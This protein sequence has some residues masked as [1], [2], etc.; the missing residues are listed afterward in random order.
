MYAKTL[1]D[2]AMTKVPVAHELVLC[3][4]GLRQSFTSRA[5]DYQNFEQ[6]NEDCQALESAILPV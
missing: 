3:R 1:K 4:L 6:R 5:I 2:E